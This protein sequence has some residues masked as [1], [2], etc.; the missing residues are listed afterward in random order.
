MKH[1]ICLLLAATLPH[2]QANPL[3]PLTSCP[4]DTA[5]TIVKQHLLLDNVS[6]PQLTALGYKPLIADS[7]NGWSIHNDKPEVT[8]T[9]KDG[10]ISGKGEDLK[11]NSFLYTTAEYDNYLLYFEFRFDHRKGNSGL[12]YHSKYNAANKFAGIQYE[13]DPG[14]KMMGAIN[15]QWT[16]LLYAENLGGWHYPNRDGAGGKEKATQETMLK[17][18]KEGTAN[19]ARTILGKAPIFRARDRLPC[20]SM[21]VSPVP[22]PGEI[23]T[24]FPLV[25][26]IIANRRIH[27]R[28]TGRR[29]TGNPTSPQKSQDQSLAP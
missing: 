29:P 4:T 10:V 23:S 6:L 20:R 14:D 8:F 18:S 11:G 16:G 9:L 25:L 21:A 5:T 7:L 26:K 19:C 2:L 22:S 12:M 24:F 3:A 17:L 13:M 28:D 15:R 27:P 1:A